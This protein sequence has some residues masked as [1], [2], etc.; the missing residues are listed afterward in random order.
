MDRSF[1]QVVLLRD[2]T[3]LAEQ[4]VHCVIGNVD[5]GERTDPSR[6][7]SEV[8][9]RGPAAITRD[10]VRLQLAGRFEVELGVDITAERKEAA[11]HKAISR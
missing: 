5:T 10:E 2:Q 3:D 9:D 4:F 7:L 8:A 11:P 1:G 6:F